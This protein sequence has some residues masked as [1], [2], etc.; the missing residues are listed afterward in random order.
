MPSLA[1]LQDFDD[2]GIPL[3]SVAGSLDLV[4]MQ[5]ILDKVSAFVLGYVGDKIQLPLVPPIDP[6][7]TTAVVQIA[8]W[9]MLVRRGFEPENESDKVV[10]QGFLDAMAWLKD[11]ANGKVRLDQRGSNPE[12]LQP[13]VDTNERRGYGDVRGSGAT[14][15]PFLGPN[16]WGG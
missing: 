3:E 9:R 16:N 2:E 5:R 15:D 8:A 6:P 14:D 4:Q 10:R 11:V 12:S 13:S 7:I 1:T